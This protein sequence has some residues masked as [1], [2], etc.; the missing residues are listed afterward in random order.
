MQTANPSVNDAPICTCASLASD[1][2][3]SPEPLRTVVHVVHCTQPPSKGLPCMSQTLLI[4]IFIR[5][6]SQQMKVDHLGEG[7]A[8]C[9]KAPYGR[10]RAWSHPP[11]ALGFMNNSYLRI[12]PTLPTS[13]PA[14]TVQAA[15]FGVSLRLQAQPQEATLPQPAD[16]RA[17]T[18]PRRAAAAADLHRASVCSHHDT[19]QASF[20]PYVFT[21][22]PITHRLLS[23]S[24]S[25]FSFPHSVKIYEY[26]LCAWPYVKGKSDHVFLLL[27][28]LRIY[29][30]P[31]G[32]EACTFQVSPSSPVRFIHPMNIY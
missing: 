12:C 17:H 24:W 27:R 5:T 7:N 1:A 29:P 8:F 19:P 4:C 3:L 14:M 20:P 25:P 30:S 9:T 23:C 21:G 16:S 11:G 26:L 31:L 15:G 6:V 13:D 32:S 10:D 2:T 18:I 28:A 22:T